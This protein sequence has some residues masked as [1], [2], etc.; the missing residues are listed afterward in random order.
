MLYTGPNVVSKRLITANA[1]WI[2]YHKNVRKRS[3]SKGKQ[4]PQTVAKPGST[5]NKLMARVSWDWQGNIHYEFLPPGKTINLD[6]YYQQL[7]TLKQ[8]VEK[9]RPESINRK[10]VVFDHYNARP[11]TFL[12]TQQIL[13]GFGWKVLMHPLPELAPSDFHLFRS[14][15]NSLDSVSSLSKLVSWRFVRRRVSPP[16]ARARPR[17]AVCV[18][19]LPLVITP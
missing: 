18:R 19:P 3:Y 8:E 1:K 2:I 12:A 17:A 13:R 9:K 15:Q 14:L 6:L 5:H 11:P 16:G 10:D 7:M 4:A